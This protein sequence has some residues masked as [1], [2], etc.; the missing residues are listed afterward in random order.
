[1]AVNACVVHRETVMDEEERLAWFLEHWYDKHIREEIERMSQRL[2]FFLAAS[3]FLLAAYAALASRWWGCGAPT[4]IMWVVVGA[5]WFLSL[6]FYA[7]NSWNSRIVWS[8][9][10]W[11]RRVREHG[12]P[13]CV[14][15]AAKSRIEKWM[16]RDE[17]EKV[18]P[19]PPAW[20]WGHGTVP[21]LGAGAWRLSEGFEYHC[22]FRPGPFLDSCLDVSLAGKAGLFTRVVPAV[23]LVAWTAIALVMREASCG[24][25]V[26]VFVAMAVPFVVRCV[27]VQRRKGGKANSPPG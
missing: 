4:I 20:L 15:A 17:R 19:M 25:W 13:P 18:E 27:V 2:S 6:V 26:V 3:T 12:D 16:T 10:N 22:W 7:S 1:M 24:W 9:Y 5:G 8:Y 14:R 23:L 21:G 11:L